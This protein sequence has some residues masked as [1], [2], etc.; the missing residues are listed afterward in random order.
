MSNVDNKDL[1]AAINKAMEGVNFDNVDPEASGFSELPDGYFLTS[2]KKAEFGFSKKGALQVAMQFKIE[3]NGVELTLDKYN[4]VVQ[5]E[6]KGTKG[7]IIFKYYN[8]ETEDKIL[9]FAN[10]MAKFEDENGDQLI[11]ADAFK[12]GAE[13]L[14]DSLELLVQSGSRVYVKND[15]N[16]NDDGTSSSWANLVSWKTAEKLGLA[17]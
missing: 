5:K 6:L 1:L 17:V 12:S 10:D 9:K 14:L 2:V 4:N 15:V 7:R 16:K 3:E 13:I 8:Y 11:D